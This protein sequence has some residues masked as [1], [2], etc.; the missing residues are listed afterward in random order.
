MDNFPTDC[1][2]IQVSGVMTPLELDTINQIPRPQT[3]PFT[4]IHE[5]YQRLHSITIDLAKEAENFTKSET[6]GNV[7]SNA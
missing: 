5:E 4:Q 7:V 6:Q 2:T 3:I 1:P